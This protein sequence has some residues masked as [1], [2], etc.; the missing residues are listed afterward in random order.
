MSYNLSVGGS[1]TV[2]DLIE[3]LY[4]KYLGGKADWWGYLVSYFR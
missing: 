1:F 2:F 3:S 4:V